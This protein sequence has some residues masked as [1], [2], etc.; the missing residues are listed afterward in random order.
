MYISVLARRALLARAT[1]ATSQVFLTKRLPAEP[2][3]SLT[4][5]ISSARVL[6]QSGS[7]KTSSRWIKQGLFSFKPVVFRYKQEIDPDRRGQFGLVAEDVEKIN[8][9]W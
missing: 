9:T 5:T 1:A 6:P 4:Q 7:R 2:R 3:F 8:P